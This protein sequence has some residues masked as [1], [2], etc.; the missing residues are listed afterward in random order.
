MRTVSKLLK[1]AF[2][3]SGSASIGEAFYDVWKSSN[4]GEAVAA[5]GFVALENAARQVSQQ[6]RMSLSVFEDQ[7]PN[8]SR[9]LYHETVKNMSKK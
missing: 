8:E 3:T 6:K 9:A 2:E 1:Q 7:F 5:E 4:S